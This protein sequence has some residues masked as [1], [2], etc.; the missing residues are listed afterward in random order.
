MFS[1]PVSMP[2]LGPTQ[3]IK[4]IPEVKRSEREADDLPKFSA[5]VKIGGAIIS[6]P[7]CLHGRAL[8]K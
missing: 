2:A 3:P 4:W 1:I 6:T 8:H 7:K 5:D